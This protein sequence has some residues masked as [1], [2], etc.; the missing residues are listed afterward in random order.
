MTSPKRSGPSALT[1]TL[2]LTLLL[3][4]LSV[5][6][7]DFMQVREPDPAGESLEPGLYTFPGL[8]SPGASLW[9]AQKIAVS[10]FNLVNALEKVVDAQNYLIVIGEDCELPAVIQL[11]TAGSCLVLRSSG[12]ERR[13]GYAGSR[14]GG[15]LFILERSEL[16]LE[17]GI[18]LAG[19]EGN[20]APLVQLGADSSFTMYD[21]SKIVDNPGGGVLA[22]RAASSG[23]VFTMHGGEISGCSK[24]AGDGAGVEAANGAIFTMKGGSIRGNEALAGSGGG[25]AVGGGRFVL[26]CGEITGNRASGAGGGVSGSFT[27]R[28]GSVAGNASGSANGLVKNVSRAPSM[29]GQGGIIEDWTVVTGLSGISGPAVTDRG[30]SAGYSVTVQGVGGQS[31]EVLWT[32][33][34]PHHV[35]TTIDSASGLLTVAS[36]EINP[37]LRIKAQS[38]AAPEFTA[39]LT[40]TVPQV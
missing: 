20:T 36:G 4:C 19:K 35:Y 3:S 27:M 1:P 29:E 32:I 39:E 37:T 13:I 11:Y 22:G 26:E 25:V 10:P 17:S 23:A 9:N 5:S 30:A 15:A 8:Y 7:D 21:G 24:A 2:L 33:E 12:G 34:S 28:G 31:R 40:I 6:C 18:V 14:S 38:V 16:I